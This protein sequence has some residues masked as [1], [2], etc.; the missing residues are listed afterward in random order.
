INEYL[1]EAGI[2]DIENPLDLLGDAAKYLIYEEPRD[3]VP[4]ADVIRARNSA[5]K[6]LKVR[7]AVNKKLHQQFSQELERALKTFSPLFKDEKG[8]WLDDSRKAKIPLKR[9]RQ[10]FES[11]ALSREDFYRI[12]KLLFLTEAVSD[13]KA[14][15]Y[16]S[17]D[18]ASFK[19]CVEGVVIAYR[20]YRLLI[21]Q[22]KEFVKRNKQWRAPVAFSDKEG[23]EVS[24]DVRHN[25][26]KN[27]LTKVEQDVLRKAVNLGKELRPIEDFRK[28]YDFSLPKLEAL[29]RE[30]I[31]N[32]LGIRVSF[33]RRLSALLHTRVNGKPL[34]ELLSL[35]NDAGVYEEAEELKQLYKLVRNL[36]LN[37]TAENPELGEIFQKAKAV[38]YHPLVQSISLIEPPVEKYFALDEYFFRHRAYTPQEIEVLRAIASFY[39]K[40]EEYNELAPLSKWEEFVRRFNQLKVLTGGRKVV[41]MGK[42]SRAQFFARAEGLRFIYKISE[43]KE[44]AGKLKFSVI[45]PEQL[46]KAINVDMLEGDEGERYISFSA[47]KKRDELIEALNIIVNNPEASFWREYTLKL[48][49]KR[50]VPYGYPDRDSLSSFTL[51]FKALEEAKQAEES[52]DPSKALSILKKWFISERLL[53][54]VLHFLHQIK[55]RKEEG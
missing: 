25:P 47:V 20:R 12:R 15:L 41:G 43:T 28:N 1:K 44:V 37:F 49:N 30:G 11:L 17:M 3:E 16:E 38:F 34:I 29:A 31:T 45:N 40:I 35:W 39:E 4:V 55:E 42:F 14:A 13:N 27:F 33:S 51:A 26:P 54:E 2:E 5:D 32:H 22:F 6:L 19:E 46:T 23:N 10:T 48:D 53:K 18:I 7:V 8:N 24:E 9:L 36:K 50:T 21:K 52:E